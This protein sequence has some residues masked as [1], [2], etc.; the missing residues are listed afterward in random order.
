MINDS[1]PGKVQGVKNHGFTDALLT[2]ERLC[3]LREY[4]ESDIR[5]KLEKFEISG[6]ERDRVIEELKKNGFLSD[7]RYA[8]AFVRDRVRLRGW[9]RNK[10]VFMLRCKKIEQSVIDLAIKEYPE[11]SGSGYLKE[12]LL[13]KSRAIREDSSRQ[14]CMAK[15]VR[16]AL[17]R[18]FEYDEVFKEVNKIIDQRGRKNI[19][20]D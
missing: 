15:L 8:T 18:G 1:Q 17:S 14:E 9:G 13:K 19:D 3:S 6:Q 7:L 11:N 20:D 10:I 4:C 16:F 12:L 5:K 2:T